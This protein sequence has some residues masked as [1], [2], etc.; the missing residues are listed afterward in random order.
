MAWTEADRV[1]IR[2]YTGASALFVQSWPALEN[3]ITSIQSQADGGQRPDNST[4]TL[5]RGYLT[6]LAAID[7][8][9]QQDSQLLMVS[10]ADEADVDYLR[11]QAGLQKLGRMWVHRLCRALAFQGPLVDVF[12]G[13]STVPPS[14]FAPRIVPFG[15]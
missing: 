1:Q 5:I 8:Q 14:E 9:L 15:S 3:A 10:H 13:G 7:V 12:S 6:S 11:K 2:Q 4:E